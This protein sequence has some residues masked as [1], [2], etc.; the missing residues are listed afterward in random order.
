[1]STFTITCANLKAIT[2]S[3][4][5][6]ITSRLKELRL[7][8]LETT[9]LDWSD[10]ANE[11]HYYN[12]QGEVTVQSFYDKVLAGELPEAFVKQFYDW[13][14]KEHKQLHSDY[15]LLQEYLDIAEN[16]SS[17]ITVTNREFKAIMKAARQAN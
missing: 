11:D 5:R 3:G 17:N 14:K 12:W 15:A 1:M 8:N 9:V 13:D 16:A 7:P 10:P 4:Q 6:I 2:E